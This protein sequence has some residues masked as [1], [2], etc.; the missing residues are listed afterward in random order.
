LLLAAAVMFGGCETIQDQY[1]FSGFVWYEGVVEGNY[2]EVQRRV[3]YGFQRCPGAG[4]PE[5]LDF[6]GS[7]TDEVRIEVFQRTWLHDRSDLALGIIKIRRLSADRTYL[8][9][10]VRSDFDK[11]IEGGRGYYSTLWMDFAQGDYS[12]SPGDQTSEE[13]A[14]EPPDPPD[15]MDS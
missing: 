5:T 8:Q 3:T 14:A 6:T 7:G 10:G 13:T 1:E 9:V 12:C 4:L 15:L 2:R 11:P